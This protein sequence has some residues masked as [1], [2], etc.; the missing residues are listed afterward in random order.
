MSLIDSEFDR[1]IV[2]ARQLFLGG[3]EVPDRLID[4]VVVR[5]WERSRR[6]GLAASDKVL[7]N[8]V[9]YSDQR[10]VAD[11]NRALIAHV[12]PELQRLYAALGQADWIVACVNAQGMVVRSL[13]AERPTCRDIG[14]ALRTGVDLSEDIAGT[15]GP[16]CALIEA[17]PVVISGP[18][19]FLDEARRYSCVAVPI[20]DPAGAVVG[21]LDASRHHDGRRSGILEPLALAVRSIENGMVAALPGALR[22]AVHY[23]P[24]LAASQMRGILAFSADGELLGANP[25]ARQLLE[26]DVGRRMD[27]DS[28]FG[29]PFAGLMDTLR[30]NG[31]TAVLLETAGGV[32]VHARFDVD[33]LRPAAGVPAAARAAASTDRLPSRASSAD[34]AQRAFDRDVPVLIGGETGTGKEVLARRL[35]ENG[36]RRD[37]PFIAINCS[38]MP[39]SLIESE[40]FGYEAGAFT[41]ARRGGMVGKFEQANGG[42]LFLDEIGDMPLELQ[43]RLLRVLQEHELTRLG[44]GSLVKLDFSLI[45]ATHSDLVAMV[46]RQQF[47]SDLYYRINGLRVIL[48]PLRERKDIDELIGQLLT[49]ESGAL[50]APRL[51]AAAR[52]ALL[53]YPW[54][55][56]IRELQQALRLGVALAENGEIDL[57]HLPVEIGQ[58]GAAQVGM[59]L[60]E[61]AEVEAVRA[62]MRQHGGNVSAAARSL[63]IARATLYRKLRQF[64]LL[65]QPDGLTH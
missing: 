27:F 34:I 42:T 6:R 26:F 47:R 56:N 1:H 50:A 33:A 30:R 52:S 64:D 7:F 2:R 58:C 36:P 22:I 24:E 11:A 37:G 40:L 15:T 39:A 63:G 65:T 9:S 29:R 31:N 46:A 59:G 57:P 60:L 38:A 19:H 28:L 18:E 4:A 5:S 21:A 55:G 44:G 16:S 23:V 35:H 54:P 51:S 14:P 10:R 32:R 41:G 8:H 45:C 25:F 3:C 43:T 49:D 13:G 48:P 20:L 17:R 12:E 61:R 62:A 53:R